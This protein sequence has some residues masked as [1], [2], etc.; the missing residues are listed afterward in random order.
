M[1][2]TD[3]NLNKKTLYISIFLLLNYSIYYFYFGERI[4]LNNGFG[5]DGNIYAGYVQNFWSHISHTDDVYHVNRVLPSFIVYCFLK[6]LHLDT[7]S[8][9]NIVNGF[10]IL[11]SICFIL[12]AYFWFKIC[13]Y[14]KFLSNTYW[15]GFIS[16]FVNFLFLKHNL[17]DAVLTDTVAIFLGMLSL[18]CYVQKKYLLLAATIIPAYFTWP[19]SIVL[20]VPLLLFTKVDTIDKSILNLEQYLSYLLTTLFI[21][22]CIYLTYIIGNTKIVSNSIDIF[23]PLLPLSILM[24]ALFMHCVILYS[25]LLYSLQTF[26]QIN[27]NNILLLTISVVICS[28]IYI[29]LKH[30]MPHFDTD[31]PIFTLYD[32]LNVCI[33]GA[34]ARPGLFLIAHLS[35]LGP[36][37]VLVLLYARD[38]LEQSRQEGMGFT[39]LLLL[40]AFLALN[41]QTR[42]IDFNY[43]YIVYALC[44]VLNNK[45]VTNKFLLYYLSAGFIISKVYYPINVAPLTGSVLDF[46]LQRL[47]MNSGTYMSWTG[48]FINISLFIIAYLFIKRGSQIKNSLGN[49]ARRIQIN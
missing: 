28:I 6:L 30:H 4:P 15:M 31:K 35:F 2:L 37:V 21:F 14:K 48:Y 3:K 11:N 1:I 20:I 23:Y 41:S 18:Y 12:T 8:P 45:S 10:M 42:Q 16:L 26:T 43:P 46:P 36:V 40:T 9:H 32:L 47:M 39:I 19:I 7:Y 49:A 17:Y 33:L 25:R 13:E 5:W 44:L 22:I 24:A 38:I 34:I 29:W 27:Y